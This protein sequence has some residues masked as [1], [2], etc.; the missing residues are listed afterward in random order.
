MQPWR[1]TIN[2]DT[3]QPTNQPIGWANLVQSALLRVGPFWTVF[4]HFGMLTN[5]PCLAIFNPKRTIFGP[6]PVM[7]R[8]PQSK[9]QD[10]S[11]DL[12]CVACL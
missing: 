10:S 9:K 1:R 5:G 3:D 4:D 12:L 8:G 2:G 7:N 11:P 6:S